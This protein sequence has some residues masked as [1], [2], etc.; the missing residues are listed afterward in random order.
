MENATS[1]ATKLNAFLMDLTAMHP[2]KNAGIYE[3][4]LLQN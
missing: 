3:I 4:L 2:R 1:I